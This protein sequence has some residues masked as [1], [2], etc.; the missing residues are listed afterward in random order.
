MAISKETIGDSIFQAADLWRDEVNARMVAAGYPFMGE[1][2]GQLLQYIAPTGTPQTKIVERAGMTKQA[3]Q[4][5]LDG[6]VIDGI[7]ERKEDNKDARRKV[8]KFTEKGL[9]ARDA[10]DAV[11]AEVEDL[12]ESFLGEKRAKNFRRLLKLL[13]EAD[14]E[15]G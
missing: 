5:H 12:F 10:G 11:R 3:V 6:L 8:I 2:R 7:V 4:Q 14:P 13:L 15:N 1:A 9:A